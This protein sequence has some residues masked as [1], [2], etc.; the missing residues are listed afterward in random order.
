[1]HNLKKGANFD[2]T[3]SVHAPS[4]AKRRAADDY[5]SVAALKQI[6]SLS[7]ALVPLRFLLVY[8]ME[9]RFK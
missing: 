8:Y 3:Y 9:A 1:M 5:A 4:G 6:I 2:A 7:W